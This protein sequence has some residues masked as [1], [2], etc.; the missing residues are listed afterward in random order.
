MLQQPYTDII[1]SSTTSTRRAEQLIGGLG[2]ERER[3]QESAERL[4]ADLKNLVGN[5]MLASGCLAYLGP[6]TSQF[7]KVQHDVLCA[8]VSEGICSASQQACGSV[9][10]CACPSGCTNKAYRIVGGLLLPSF[11]SSLP[12]RPTLDT[13]C[14]KRGGRCGRRALLLTPYRFLFY[15]TN[16]HLCLAW[17]TKALPITHRV[18]PNTLFAE[19][20][21]DINCMTTVKMTTFRSVQLCSNA[22]SS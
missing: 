13:L 10:R 22:G 20:Q 18:A 16:L 21:C 5:V 3:W 17:Y 1:T 9:D 19:V 8:V 2:D 7:R 4:S 14:C 6:F 12:S 11:C 15:L